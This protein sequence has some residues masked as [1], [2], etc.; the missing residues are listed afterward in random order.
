MNN[1]IVDTRDLRYILFEVLN[2]DSLTKFEL[3]SSF[4]H[5]TF[6]ATLN[7]IEDIA[8]K[9][10]FPYFAEAD[11]DGCKWDP[12]TGEVTVPE[13]V[14]KPL[15]A[16]YDAEL[17]GMYESPAIGGT[18]MP[19]S[20]GAAY[21]EFISAAHQ[22]LLMW[23]ALAHGSMM[24]IARFGTEEQK[25]TFIP[26]MMKGEWGGTM[27]LTEP[28]AGSDVGRLSTK[29]VKQEDGTYRIT[30]QKIFI[31]AGENDYY[32]NI[33][34]PVLARI[35]G[36]P[37]GTKGISI[38]IVPKYLVDSEGNIIKKNDIKCTGIEHKMGIKSCVTCSMSFGENGECVGYLLGKEREG[39]KI[40]FHMMNE[41]RM[42][43]AI[44]AQGVSSAAYLHAASYAKARLQGNAIKDMNNPSAPMVPIVQHPDV[45]RS[46]LWMK[47]YV[48]AQRMLIYKMFYNMDI[49]NVGTEEQR[50][51]AKALIDFMVPVLKAGCSDRN[52]LITS[53]AMQIFGGYGY[54]MDYPIEQ[55]MRN[56][57][58]LCIFEGA[59]GIQGIDLVLRKL[60][61]NPGQYNY[62]I[63]KKN[64]NESIALA[65]ETGVDNKYIAPLEK[66]LERL[67]EYVEKMK[68]MVA[69]FRFKEILSGATNF[70]KCLYML[71]MA[72]MHV[73]N[74][75]IALP[76][77]RALAGDKKGEDLKSLLTDN[78]DAAFYHSRILASRFYLM[79]EFPQFFG[80]MDSLFA[81]EWPALEAEDFVFVNTIE[82]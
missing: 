70:R 41:F 33:I 45:Q 68:S 12:A 19:Q 59:N 79:E 46:L 18:G 54:C 13:G 29:A 73:W 67:D 55:M 52:V 35:E 7:L 66:G 49:E 23:G 28:H 40:M 37:E 24:L 47:S 74:L 34:H 42:G 16:Y 30:G 1:P 11:R 20:L 78:N 39:M 58:I 17:I 36:D 80:M 56:S 3:F 43:T 57:K 6:E 50:K 26:K 15:K 4:D 53:E 31:S 10:C 65:K 62:N 71:S 75:A 61:L 5:D 60:L 25:K 72:W 82:M 81:E 9:E 76:K 77:F 21:I 32:S 14:R 44:Q 48:D 2:I 38:F 27:C 22:P 69:S 63:F 64:V 51:E 8:V